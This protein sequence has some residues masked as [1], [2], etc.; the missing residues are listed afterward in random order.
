MISSDMDY[1]RALT[2]HV[3]ARLGPEAPP[4]RILEMGYNHGI[5][6]AT[7]WFILSDEPSEHI[8]LWL[9]TGVADEWPVAAT[10]TLGVPLQ[11]AIAATAERSGRGAGDDRGALLPPCPGHRHPLQVNLVDGVAC[12]G[13]P[14]DRAHHVEPVMAA[15]EP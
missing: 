7:L 11:H 8:T 9:G 4:L 10:F 15:D 3:I 12:W 14:H 2:M 5:D 1:A 13:C 6:E